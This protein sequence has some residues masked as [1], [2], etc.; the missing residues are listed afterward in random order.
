LISLSTRNGFQAGAKRVFFAAQTTE[1]SL[2]L[3]RQPR[4]IAAI[5]SNL[6]GNG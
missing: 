1:H 3:S 5:P 6:A 4:L 2:Y